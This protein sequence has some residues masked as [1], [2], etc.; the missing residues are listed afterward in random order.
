MG[1]G[2]GWNSNQTSV[3]VWLPA[4]VVS[5][6]VPCLFTHGRWPLAR[7]TFANEFGG[8]AAPVG[9]GSPH[10]SSRDHTASPPN[11]TP[12]S[13]TGAASSVGDSPPTPSIERQR[14]QP[15]PSRPSKGPKPTPPTAIQGGGG[16]STTQSAPPPRPQ[17]GP[18]PTPPPLPKHVLALAARLGSIMDLALAATQAASLLPATDGTKPNVSTKKS[19][20]TVDTSGLSEA[21]QTAGLTPDEVRRLY[22]VSTAA[23]DISTG[24]LAALAQF[25]AGTA[26]ELGTS[27]PCK[28]SNHLCFLHLF[29][30]Y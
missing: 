24:G 12:E 10:T 28:T 3:E 11:A 15:E 22:I 14:S 20:D 6:V 16:Y 29:H 7:E 2:L 30:Y 8:P 9:L 17:K 21:E 4:S 23:F 1:L 5:N 27:C 18:K 26:R 13:G 25:V 19:T